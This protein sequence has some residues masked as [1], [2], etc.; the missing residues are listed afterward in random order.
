MIV[1]RLHEIQDRVG[2]LPDAELAA[3]AR[4]AGVP[5]Y[6]VQEV[7]SF[8][9]HFRQEWNKPPRVEVRVCRDMSCHLAGAAKLL[10]DLKGRAKPHEVEVEGVS[11]LGRCDRA[12]AC[13]IS[14]HGKGHFHDYVYAG[15]A[16]DD[17]KRIALGIIDGHDPEPPDA[18]AG[19]VP[20]GNQA[21]WQIDPYPDRSAR[22]YLAVRGY[23]QANPS[24]VRGRDPKDHP[25]L[26][27]LDPAGL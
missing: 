1:Q 15:R 13:T 19:F 18:D 4:E 6:R 11:C 21:D 25:W 5:L 22:N 14:R 20:F 8:F 9:P 12:P 16:A 2:Y 23:L 10:A 27:R 26:A 7:A 3:V 24:P 17:V